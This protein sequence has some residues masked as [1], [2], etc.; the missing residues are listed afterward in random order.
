[1]VLDRSY[2]TMKPVFEVPTHFL[3]RL[4][5]QIPQ[6]FLEHVLECRAMCLDRIS[7]F[8][9]LLLIKMIQIKGNVINVE[10]IT[11]LGRSRYRRYLLSYLLPVL[12]QRVRHSTQ[13]LLFH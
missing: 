5:S 3:F 9:W 4:S 1:M 2:L 8:R 10:M 11:Y 13:P 6:S 7:E 12:T